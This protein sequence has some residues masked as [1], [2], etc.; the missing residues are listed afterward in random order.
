M[1]LARHHFRLSGALCT[2]LLASCGKPEKTGSPNADAPPRAVRVVRAESRAMERVLYAVGTLSAYDETTVSAQVAGQIEK[3][4]VDLGDQVRAGDEL[5]MIDTAAYEALARQ[6]AA[7]LAKARASAANAERTLQRTQ[8]L[9][10]DRIAS[11]SDLD[12]A[13]AEDE[14]AKAEVKAVEAAWAIAQLNLDRSRVKSPF[15]GAVAGRIASVGSYAAVGTPIV[16]LVK[17]NPLRLQ[18]EVPE[19]DSMFVRVGQPVRITVESDTNVYTGTLARVSPAIR[20]VNRML[21]VEADVPAQ[22][23][24]RPGLF[25]RAQIVVKEDEQSVSLP[26]HTL[27]TFAGLEKVVSVVEGKALEKTVTTGRQGRDW[28]EIVSGVTV[29]ETVVLEPTGLRTGTPL[30]IVLPGS[31]K[32]AAGDSR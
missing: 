3:F 24:L 6:A 27:I 32:T 19:R 13:V 20:E 5:A 2:L 11:S 17:T 31:G 25:T 8:E 28:V 29:G 4:R 15:D 1:N 10:R 18:L 7:N 21:P 14:Q 16:Q 12:L 30:T 26:L 23:A 22:G 9:Q